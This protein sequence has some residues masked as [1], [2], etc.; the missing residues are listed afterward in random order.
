MKKYRYHFSKL[1]SPTYINLHNYLKEQH[2]SKTRFAP[3]ADF[4]EANFQFNVDAANTLEYKDQ[5]ASLVTN[6]CFNIMPPTFNINDY[7][8]QAVLSQIAAQFY[9]GTN[10]FLD[11]KANL[12]WILKPA[13]LN[14][15]QH[16]HIFQSL[17]AIEA[18]YLSAQRLG[19][20]HVLQ[21]Y[22]T[23]P[24][25]L[26]G[27]ETGHKYSIR[28][29][30]VCTNYAGAYLYPQGY[31]NVALHPY[32]AD[33]FNRLQAH[34]T[35]EHLNDHERNVVQVPTEQY[36][37]FKRFY[38]DIKSIAQRVTQALKQKHPQ[39]FMCDSTRTLAIFG[40]DFCIDAQERVWLLEANHG[41]CFPITDNHPL[42]QKV[43]YGFWQSFISSFVQPIAQNTSVENIEYSL[44]ETLL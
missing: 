35:N 13:L 21:H 30:I 9:Q 8:W 23:Q 27:P 44:F 10:S 20:P 5:L 4:G 15:G 24:H 6:N 22:I 7:N 37:L 1:L 42:Q 43:Y 19:G 36:E 34:L 17:S 14:N 3:L 28:M 31:F 40:F 32:I 26:Q 25:L 11:Q 29:F 16:I 39:A 41:P 12:A 2:W 38:A 33:D 18:H